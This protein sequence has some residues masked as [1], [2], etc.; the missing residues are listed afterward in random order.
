MNTPLYG[1]V[2][3]GG[4]SSRLGQDKHLLIKDQ[5]PLYEWWLELLNTYCPK[6]Y[7]SCRNNQILT[8]KTDAIIQDQSEVS[9]PLEGIYRAF[10]LNNRVNWLVVAVDLVY[11][12]KQQ[13]QN[14]ISQNDPDYDAIAFKNPITKDPFPLCSIYRTTAFSEIKSNYNSPIKSPRLV[15]QNMNTL[16]LDLN[17]PNF[18]EGINTQMDLDRWKNQAI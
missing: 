5:K 14:L 11:I 1:L 13:I 18:L 6:V 17:D 3:C 2:L 10:T 12:T 7:I 16:L 9:G 15:L 8:I 4:Y